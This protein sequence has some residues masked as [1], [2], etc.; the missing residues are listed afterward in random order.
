MRVATGSYL[1]SKSDQTL[2]KAKSVILDQPPINME[3]HTGPHVEDS[4][5]AAAKL[6]F[7]AKQ[8][9][10]GTKRFQ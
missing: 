1:P 4:S 8:C 3:V 2:F 7:H 9:Y 10:L 6:H 5:L